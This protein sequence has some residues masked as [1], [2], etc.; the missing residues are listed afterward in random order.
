MPKSLI[1][2]AAVFA[3]SAA[4]KEEVARTD[5]ARMLLRMDG[6]FIACEGRVTLSMAFI[7]PIA[8]E[9]TPRFL[10]A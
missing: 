4:L 9:E 6:I 3:K 7:A 5:A 8:Q 2:E 10:H 1:A